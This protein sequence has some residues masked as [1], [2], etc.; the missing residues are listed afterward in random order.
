VDFSLGHGDALENGNGFFLHPRREFAFADKFFD[1]GKVA[2]IFVGMGV[3]RGAWC[4]I[5]RM[6]VVVMMMFVTVFM[7]AVV[8]IVTVFVVL[9][10]FVREVHVE[11]DAGDALPLLLA[12]VQMEAVEFELLDLAREFVRVHAEVE[13]RA[14]EH[15]AADAAEDVEVKSFHF[16]IFIREFR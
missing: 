8:A 14:D 15:I 7:R 9:V 13:Q 2:A 3:V 5:V 12:D 11:L 16:Q 10:V 4:V 6:S 1:V